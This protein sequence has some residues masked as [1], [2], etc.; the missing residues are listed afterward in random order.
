M[1]F[2]LQI[3]NNDPMTLTGLIGQDA[4][5]YWR[6]SDVGRCMAYKAPS[7]F[8]R[9]FGTRRTVSQVTPP[10]TCS[11]PKQ[12]LLTFPEMMHLVC[13]RLN[14][15]HVLAERIETVWHNGLV[16]V[17]HVSMDTNPNR[18]TEMWLHEEGVPVQTVV[19][20]LTVKTMEFYE[21]IQS[22]SV[23]VANEEYTDFSIRVKWVTHEVFLNTGDGRKLM[24][25][26]GMEEDS[27]AEHPL[28]IVEEDTSTDVKEE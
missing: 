25:S 22:F 4:Q 20:D 24:I 18:A 26:S 5:V 13:T 6:A 23:P 21:R 1:W 2:K 9:K 14:K 16:Q 12:V 19:A 8:A 11:Y 15:S 3:Y 27:L 10:G 17:P 28:V 7:G